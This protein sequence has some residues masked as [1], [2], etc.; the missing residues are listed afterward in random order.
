MRVQHG[1]RPV[2]AVSLPWVRSVTSLPAGS[3]L[4]A[5]PGPRKRI[6]FPFPN[7]GDDTVAVTDVVSRGNGWLA[8][9]RQILLS[10]RL[11]DERQ[12]CVRLDL[13]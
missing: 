9:G 6:A 7:V 1:S 10:A 2:R 5:S 8:V 3:R 11:R 13:E 4:M 12:A